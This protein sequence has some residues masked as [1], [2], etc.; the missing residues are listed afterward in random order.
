MTSRAGGVESVGWPPHSQVETPWRQAQRSGS[1]ADRTLSTV[2]V[3][4]PPAIA[5]L[6][7]VLRADLLVQVETAVQEIAELDRSHGRGL[8]ALS[9]LLLRTESVAS[10]KIESV[11]ASVDDYARALHGVRSNS[12]AVSMVAATEALALLMDDVSTNGTI[13]HAPILRAH[14]T[15]MQADPSE[16]AYAGRFRDLQNWI[17]GSDHSP[18]GALYVPPPPE[19]VADHV[20]DLMRFANRDDLLALPQA[21]IVHAQFESIHPFTDGNGRIGRALINAVLRR[22]GT[23][24]RV[25]VPLATSLVADRQRYFSALSAYREGDIAPIVR[26]FA[27]ASRIAAHEATRTAAR[28]QEVPAEWRGLLGP[29]RAGSAVA[30]LLD[31]LPA[32]PIMSSDDACAAVDAPRSSVFSA[33]GRLQ[34]AGVLRPLTDRRREQVWGA[35]AI[36]DELD[37]LGLRVA[38]ASR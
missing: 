17:G 7:P 32:R 22:R 9:V 26:C 19:T 21:A 16:I 35:S 28:L 5:E 3:S 34:E 30:K 25:L 23:T 20:D 27:E 10:S 12:S 37:D 18:R 1:R 15:L 6:Q 13:T 29:V 36:L 31:V 33:I 8:D 11:E 38:E 4:M 14:A 2:V 24:H